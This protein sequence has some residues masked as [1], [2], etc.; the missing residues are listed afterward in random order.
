[1]RLPPQKCRPAFPHDQDDF[2][3]KALL[4]TMYAFAL[5]A[6]AAFAPAFAQDQ[7]AAGTLHVVQGTVMT[8]S[9]GEFTTAPTDVVLHLGDR[10]MLSDEAKATFI[11]DNGLVLHYESPG[12]YTVTAAP[13][14]TRV[15][16]TGAGST[17]GT[18]ATILGAAALAAV[19]LD[20]MDNVEPD[21]AISH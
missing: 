3:M 2:K 7:P 18:I 12:V 4:R 8:S 17:T 21:R 14:P 1:L 5:L 6:G 13:A 10:I 9:G 20:S 19:A 15:S 11:Y 16:R